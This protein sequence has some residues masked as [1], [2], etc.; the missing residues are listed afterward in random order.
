MSDSLQSELGFGPFF[1]AQMA[2]YLDALGEEGKTLVAAR[3]AADSHG[4]YE[5]VGCRASIGEL[6]GKL[7][8]KLSGIQRPVTGDWVLIADAPSP[9]HAVIHHVFDRK[10]LMMRR[11]AGSQ[12][13]AQAI[14]AN[15][16]IFCIV[17]SANRDLNVRRIERY[18]TVVYDSGAMPLIVLNKA[19]LADDLS[20]MLESIREVAPAVDMISV[21]AAT[22]AGMEAFQAFVRPG[23]T[24]GFVGSSGVGKSSIINRL[25][26]QDAQVVHEIR[27]DGKGRHTTTRRELFLL[28]GGGVL[29]D[30]P[31]MRELGVVDDSGGVDLTFSDIAELAAGCRFGDCQHEGEPGCAVVEA[32][33]QGKLKG[34][35]LEGYHRIQRE[36]A[37]AQARQNPVLA[38]NT[39]RR[40]KSIHKEM[41]SFSKGGERK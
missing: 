21:S 19:D 33:R 1:L 41:R 38:A 27:K 40:W 26:H 11:A 7:L 25:L 22:G 32:V 3:V 23:I 18:L 8:S 2:L 37:S 15:V 14:A 16:D 20:P 39:K 10:T 35:R 31:G 29:I 5:L 13:A 30:T 34:D 9:E 6:T 17:T 4:L 36:I 28:P 12:S 24:I